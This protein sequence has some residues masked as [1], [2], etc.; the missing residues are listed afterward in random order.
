MTDL[1]FPSGILSR[2]LKVFVLQRCLKE[3]E[4]HP[5][6]FNIKLV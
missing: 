4:T 1:V 3:K 2:F 6:P 5:V